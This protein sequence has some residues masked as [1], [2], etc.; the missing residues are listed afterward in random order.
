M[1]EVHPDDKFPDET[2][3]EEEVMAQEY[4]YPAEAPDPFDPEYVDVT[5]AITLMRIYD[6]LMAQ[7][8]ADHPERGVKLYEIHAKGGL[9]GPPPAFDPEE[10]RG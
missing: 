5:N 6:V 3:D 8:M 4:E 10:V 9:M 7:Y 2:K 1:R